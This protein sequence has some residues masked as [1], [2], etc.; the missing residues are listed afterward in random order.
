MAQLQSAVIA[1]D[2][3]K[4][5]ALVCVDMGDAWSATL[6]AEAWLQALQTASAAAERGD[7]ATLPDAARFWKLC[8]ALAAGRTQP[9]AADALES[10]EAEGLPSTT[11]IT[12]VE[13]LQTSRDEDAGMPPGVLQASV[14]MP[15]VLVPTR[16]DAVGFLEPQSGGHF[17]PPAQAQQAAPSDRQTDALFAE[18]RRL[19]LSWGAG[20]VSTSCSA[21]TGVGCLGQIVSRMSAALRFGIQGGGIAIP[22]L[23]SGPLPLPCKLEP[24]GCVSLPPGCD[25]DALIADSLAEYAGDDGVLPTLAAVLPQHGED[26]QAAMAELL[27]A[28]PASVSLRWRLFKGRAVASSEK[29][30]AA[31]AL[32]ALP[33]PGA[34]AESL[35]QEFPALVPGKTK[36]S[37]S[38][39]AAQAVS[40]AASA[41][42]A[43][44]AK[45]VREARE[46]EAQGS[47]PKPTKPHKAGRGGAQK[48]D[49]E[50]RTEEVGKPGL[51]SAGGTSKS[52]RRTTRRAAKQSSSSGGAASGKD[53]ADAKEFFASMLG[54]TGGAAVGGGKSKKPSSTK[55]SAR[56]TRARTRRAKAAAEADE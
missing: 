18:L 12:L 24:H 53:T 43:D 51:E 52:S 31:V 1:A 29:S 4:T 40:Q 3:R 56:T 41:A 23:A 44:L 11:P 49:K 47:G 14:G 22:G 16:M 25:C 9:S 37:A 17:I 54:P 45:I 30:S 36:R 5:V 34:W 19:A 6:Q 38:A 20:L 33:E 55:T 21:G 28:S 10:K 50:A 32:D 27:A 26:A 8:R 46:E 48:Q 39:A 35:A 13:A 15:V 2:P 7:E 42:E